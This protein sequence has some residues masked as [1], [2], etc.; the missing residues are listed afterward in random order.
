MPEDHK[1]LLKKKARLIADLEKIRKIRE[2]KV[3]QLQEVS[4]EI[5][6][7]AVRSNPIE[8]RINYFAPIPN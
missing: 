3:K 7:N 4:K 5:E 6:S 8:H 1:K 2:R